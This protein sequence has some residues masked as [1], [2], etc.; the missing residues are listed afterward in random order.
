MSRNQFDKLLHYFRFTSNLGVKLDPWLR[1]LQASF[2]EVLAE[3]FQSIDEIM[4][5]FKG[6]SSLHQ[7]MPGKANKVSQ[8]GV[9]GEF[10][11]S[12]TKTLPKHQR[13]QNICT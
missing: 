4:I 10:V 8:C 12:L 3:E 13:F 6:Q 7:Y 2:S 11:L 9:S 5:A 1:A